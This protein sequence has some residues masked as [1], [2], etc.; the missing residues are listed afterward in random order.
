[1]NEAQWTEWITREHAPSRASKSG[2]DP[3][4][5]VVLYVL[6]CM[7][8]TVHIGLYSFQ[9]SMRRDLLSTVAEHL[10]VDHYCC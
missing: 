7:Y 4:S 1:M 5:F 3:P 10:L 2:Q 6:Y 9:S 8:C